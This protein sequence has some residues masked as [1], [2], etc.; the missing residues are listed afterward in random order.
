MAVT[1]VEGVREASFSFDRAEGFVTYDT[2]KTS[3]PDIIA[4]LERLTDFT[5]TRRDPENE[6]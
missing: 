2:T 4:E 6:R 1:R 3:L 5:A